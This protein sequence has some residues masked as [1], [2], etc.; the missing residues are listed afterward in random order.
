LKKTKILLFLLL[1]YYLAMSAAKLGYSAGYKEGCTDAMT[2]VG[3][4]NIDAGMAW[5]EVRTKRIF[6]FTIMDILW[7]E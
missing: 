6:D 5:C 2:L 3:G 4:P 7:M 1:I